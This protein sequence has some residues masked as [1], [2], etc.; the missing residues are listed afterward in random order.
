MTDPAPAAPA[1]LA[2]R[3]P[4]PAA[5]AALK[6]VLIVSPAFAPNSTPDSQR[7]RM[8]LPHFRANGWEPVVLAVDPRQVEA[9]REDELLETLPPDVR[10]VHCPALPIRLSRLLGLGNLGLR[11]FLPLLL[12]GRRLL[13]REQID[14]V[15][16]S[17]TQFA[18]L[19]LGRVWRF[20]SGTPY[21][22]DLQDPWRT[23]YYERAGVRKP[24]GGWKY[25]FARAQ[26][27]LL[28]GWTFRRL[29]GLISVSP[30]YV[31]D[32]GRRYPWFGAVPTAAIRFGASRL[33]Q[34][35]ALGRQTPPRAPLHP[36][37]PPAPD[38]AGDPRHLNLV[39]TGAAGPITPHAVNI[40]LEALRRFRIASP[41]AAARIRLRFLGTSYAA[42]ESAART[43]AP[44]AAAFGVADL[45]EEQPG[46]LGH[47]ETLRVQSQA[48]ALLLLGSSDPAY[49]PSKLYPYYLAR[50]P[51]LAVVFQGSD[52]E[53]LLLEL[54][55]STLASCEAPDRFE[56]AIG[57]ILGFFADA[58]NGFGRG[59]LGPRDELSFENEY[60]APSL[61]ARQV[62]LFNDALAGP[63]AAH[64]NVV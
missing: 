17:T 11:A 39:Y 25:Q 29:G 42:P 59:A 52:L 35:V 19:P 53:K 2:A 63:T 32:L 37:P 60:L 62:A 15:Y 1:S 47:L 61:T 48:D 12:A 21:V 51:I 4:A 49:S 38:A 30:D 24:P 7:V 10:I 22:I 50:R 26:A 55:C 3:L 36:S 54:R 27:A 28:E 46:R 20:C 57:T 33:D 5:G 43:I 44:I 40:L 45:I 16:F 9:P 58:V 31:R 6:R 13:R 56:A 18:V 34:E 8:S 14:L 41:V 23:D 64:A